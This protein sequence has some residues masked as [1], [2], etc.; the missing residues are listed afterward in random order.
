MVKMMTD[1][2]YTVY[3]LSLKLFLFNNLYVRITVIYLFFRAHLSSGV[4][5][6]NCLE[7][8]LENA[9]P[10]GWTIRKRML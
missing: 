4:W 7:D 9:E 10:A 1:F 6:P 2:Y 3:V 5:A 8:R